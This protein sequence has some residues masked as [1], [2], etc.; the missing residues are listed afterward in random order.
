MSRRAAVVVALAAAFLPPAWCSADEPQVPATWTGAPIAG[1][2]SPASLLHP[3]TLRAAFRV[4]R[5]GTALYVGTPWY[6]RDLSVTVVGPGERRETI[7]ATTDLPGRMLGLRLPADA[8]QADRVELEATTVSAAA[9]PYLLP[10]EQ[11]AQI[12]WRNWWYAALFGL[13]AMLALLHGALAA[14]LRSRTFA[15]FA[16]AMAGEAGLLVPW[17]GIVRPPPEISQPLHA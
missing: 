2:S 14:M 9:P 7:A 3:A 16:A 17:L 15:W 12:G 6:V 4:P 1:D 13:F 5:V 10:A 8:W 11:L